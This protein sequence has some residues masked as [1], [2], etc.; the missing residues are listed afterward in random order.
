[1]IPIAPQ[2][3][4]LEF[5]LQVRQPGLHF[6]ATNPSPSSNDWEAHWSRAIPWLIEGYKHICAYSCLR[7]YR[8]AND[9][10]VDHYLPKSK[11]PTLAYEWANFRLCTLRMN[12]RKWNHEDVLDPFII[13]PG[14][15]VLDFQTVLIKPN[16]TLDD[17][18]RNRVKATIERLKLN[19]EQDIQARL[20]RI[21]DYIQGHYT[22]DHLRTEAP[23]I[24]YELMRQE[25]VQTILFN[26][27][28]T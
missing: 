4:P 2:P 25:L 22:F 27:L 3:E 17:G 1:V 12:R 21:Q 15:F 28:L 23:F 19:H 11:Y 9:P 18:L 16:T 13:Q 20:S 26:G 10:T 24:A 6:L 7:I 8:D 14:W 5:D